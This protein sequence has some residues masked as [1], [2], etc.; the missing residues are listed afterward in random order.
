MPIGK[1]QLQR[2]QVILMLMRQGR[3][4]NYTRFMNYMKSQLF[5]AD[6]ELSQKT[7]LRDVK[8]LRENFNAPVVYCPVR[9]GYYLTH[10]D[11]YDDNLPSEPYEI[12]AALLSERIACGILPEPLRSEMNKALSSLLMKNENGMAEGVELENFQVLAPANH[13]AVDPEIFLTCYKAWEE[14]KY[15][16]L[17]YTSAEQKSSEKVF[18][19]HVFVWR[20]GTWYLK[21]KVTRNDEERYNDPPVRVLALQRISKAELL[22]FTFDSDPEILE[23]IK[24]KGLFNFKTLPLVELEFF[25]PADLKMYEQYCQ[26][27]G[28]VKER[29]EN[30]VVIQFKDI[31][32]YEAAKL[33]LNAFGHARIHQPAELKEYVRQAA[34]LILKNLED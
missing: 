34:E 18:E 19:A 5:A 22:N 4:P 13:P 9:Q 32:E 21:G 26:Q 28:A 14:H 1:N 8:V 6:Y 25:R 24:E 7:F 23:S 12:K 10:T 16:R 17:H 2:L 15:L 29:K 27:P 30:S 20:N 33:V 31:T 11:W 3:Y